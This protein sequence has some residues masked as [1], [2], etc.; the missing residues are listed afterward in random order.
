MADAKQTLELIK[1]MQ[2][3]CQILRTAV[4]FIDLLVLASSV[5]HDKRLKYQMLLNHF[6]PQLR[7]DARNTI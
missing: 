1:N 4:I 3:T 5:T 7:L 6:N 2:H